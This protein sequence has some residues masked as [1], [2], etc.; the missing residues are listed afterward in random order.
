MPHKQA[1]QVVI[2]LHVASAIAFAQAPTGTETMET[3]RLRERSVGLVY[4]ISNTHLST[5]SRMSSY[6]ELFALPEPLRTATLEHVVEKADETFALMAAEHLIRTASGAGIIA[7]KVGDWSDSGQAAVSAKALLAPV[8]PALLEISRNILKKLIL[9]PQNEITAAELKAPGVAGRLLARSTEL[10]DQTLVRQ[11]LTVEPQLPGL[12]LARAGQGGLDPAERIR[13]SKIFRDPNSQK[14]IKLATAVALVPG[15]EEARKFVTDTLRMFLN[16]FASREAE[17][18]IMDGYYGTNG[19][20]E[21][22]TFNTSL[23]ILGALQFLDARVAEPITFEFLGSRNQYIRNTLG[24]IAAIR[25]PTRLMD[26]PNAPFD[27]KERIRLLAVVSFFHPELN[28][29]FHQKVSR[30]VLVDARQQFR[31]LGLEGLFYLSGWA[32]MGF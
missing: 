27:E 16:R 13:A 17:A 28:D 15:D 19:G 6:Q 14:W 5:T 21:F 31:D 3:Q 23:K 22:M 26:L 18:V 29:T 2:A 11:V 25:W 10:Q 30:Q 7:G 9:R 8:D 20:V 4:T 24:I 1:H 32:A 12:W